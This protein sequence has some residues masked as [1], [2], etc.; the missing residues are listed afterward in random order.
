MLTYL[1]HVRLFAT[2]RTVAHQAPLCIR[3]SWQEYQTEL[4]CPP[5]RDLPDPNPCLQHLL[6]C[7]ILDSLLLRH[8][9]RTCVCVCV[10]VCVFWPFISTKT[11]QT[12]T[13]YLGPFYQCRTLSFLCTSAV[14]LGDSINH[15]KTSRVLTLGRSG[16]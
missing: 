3:F 4:L 14:K 2:P 1:S 7:S 5:P 9:G 15:G 12:A 10:C 13:I 16:F 8:Q 6:H 11:T